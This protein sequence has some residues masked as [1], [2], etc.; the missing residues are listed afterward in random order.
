MDETFKLSFLQKKV[1]RNLM[2]NIQY[3][4]IWNI[5]VIYFYI[6]SIRRL[7]SLLNI[8]NLHLRFCLFGRI[9]RYKPS[10]YTE[11]QDMTEEIIHK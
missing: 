10:V 1:K 2:M 8:S 7:F 5:C 3:T 6:I 11:L 9:S 4:Y